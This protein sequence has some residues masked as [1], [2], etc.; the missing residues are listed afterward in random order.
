[1]ALVAAIV[2]VTVGVGVMVTSVASK[3]VTPSLKVTLHWTLASL[4]V[5]VSAALPMT[6]AT[7]PTRRTTSVMVGGMMSTSTEAVVARVANPVRLRGLP[8]RSVIDVGVAI[9]RVTG[10][11]VRAVKA[12]GVAVIWYCVVE[13]IVMA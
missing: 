5:W 13:S 9:V 2:G 12:F 8:A 10:P 4:V 7:P 6:R 1:M 11:S 3:P